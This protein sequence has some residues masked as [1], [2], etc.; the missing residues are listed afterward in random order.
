MY[1][2][3]E[4]EAMSMTEEGKALGPQPWDWSRPRVLLEFPDRPDNRARIDALRRAGFAIA[5]C[6]GPTA[7]G[8]CPLA[9]DEGCA[10]AHDADIVVSSLGLETAEGREPLEA[11][12]TRLPHVPVLVEA[13]AEVA[14]RWPELVP[15]DDRLEPGIDPSDL[16]GRVSDAL[17]RKKASDA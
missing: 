5:V 9:G 17:G 11:L 2:L 7:Q 12:R 4:A 15:E 1:V 16:V 3:R 14:A 8:H 10:A 13:D 6:S